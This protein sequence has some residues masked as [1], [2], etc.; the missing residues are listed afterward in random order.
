M[1]TVE[2]ERQ[3]EL[4]SIAAIF[5][6]LTVDAASPFVATLELAVTPAQPLLVRFNPPPDEKNALIEHDVRLSNLPP[7][8]L[9][10]TL[11]DNYPGGSPP[12]VLLSSHKGWLPSATLR[13]LEQEASNLWEE[14]GHCQI[15]FAYIDHLQQ[16]AERS[17]DLDQRAEGC[18]V[19]PSSLESTLTSF[20]IETKQATFNAGTFDCGVCLEPKKG[21][22]CYRMESCGDVF[23]KQCLQ[24]FY[25]NAITEGDVATVQCL[26]PDCSKNTDEATKSKDK[27]LHPRELL[28]IGVEVSMARRYVEMKRKKKLE[29]DPSTVF[30]PRKWCQY[31][32]RNPKYPPIP[33]DLLTYTIPDDPDRGATALS[34]DQQQ[35]PK[36]TMPNNPTDRLAICENP[37]CALA[38]CRICYAGWH[39][40][41]V[42]CFPRDP[43]ELSAEE[44]ATYDYIRAHTSPC[45]TCYSPAQKTMGCNHMKCFQC[46]SHFCYLCGAWLNVANPYQHYN[47]KGT[48]C[49]QRLWELEEGDEGQAPEDGRGFAGQR[50]W[51]QVALEAAR[52]AQ[53][54]E[55]E[56]AARAALRADN[57]RAAER[58]RE[59]DEAEAAEAERRFQEVQAEA[60]AERR[61]QLAVLR[62]GVLGGVQLPGGGA[63]RRAANGHAPAE[64][65]AAAVRAHERGGRRGGMG[66][67]QHRGGNVGANGRERPRPQL[68]N[69]G[70]YAEHGENRRGFIDAWNRA[71]E[72]RDVE[73]ERGE[74]DPVDWPQQRERG[75]GLGRGVGDYRVEDEDE[76]ED[77]DEVEELQRALAADLA[78]RR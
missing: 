62:R 16:A 24:D 6:E 57:A 38:F 42:R 40:P 34:P 74:M 41:V 50:G 43:N 8:K 59:R 12:R 13:E 5:P 17:F 3:E 20:D 78:L 72:E 68:N 9:Q 27:T 26:A 77:P 61:Q 22:F 7:L 15:L 71:A 49:Y 58:E 53:Q 44:K 70:R 64:G 56:A 75:E 45:P 1:D 29:A 63:R 51:E 18:L 67:Q 4:S 48:E 36:T 28:A 32:A 19:L 52:D 46:N 31:P 37:K 54:Q 76:F 11:P 60:E 66:Q 47:T 21:T 33:E 55:E 23:C 10:L 39:G 30:C 73:L 35:P 65:A 25:N 14:Y 69:G 2:D